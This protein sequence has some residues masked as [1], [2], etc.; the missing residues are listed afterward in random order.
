M[1][2]MCSEI[3]KRFS[4]APFCQNLDILLLSFGHS[5]TPV[6]LILMSAFNKRNTCHSTA[7]ATFLECVSFKSYVRPKKFL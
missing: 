3:D 1:L 2:H 5:L 6:L 7:N 4:V